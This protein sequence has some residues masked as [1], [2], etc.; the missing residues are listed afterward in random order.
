MTHGP[1]ENPSPSGNGQNPNPSLG[2]S[3]DVE[4]V[5]E[6]FY[7]WFQEA[8]QGK[9]FT[10]PEMEALYKVFLEAKYYRHETDSL[11]QL[12]KQLEE[13]MDTGILLAEGSASLRSATETQANTIFIQNQLIENLKVQVQTLLDDKVSRD[14]Q[15]PLN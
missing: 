15:R 11:L 14:F 3:F 2:K 5:F 8:F 10:K 7:Q 6:E 4:N 13:K 1:S 12:I 9:A